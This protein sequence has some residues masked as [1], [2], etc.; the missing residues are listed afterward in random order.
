M[1]GIRRSPSVAGHTLAPAVVVTVAVTNAG[2]P[3]VT[4]A[5]LGESAHVAPAGAPLHDIVTVCANPATDPTTIEYVAGCPAATVAVDV[6]D[7][8]TVKSGPLPVSDTVCGLPV[9]PSATESVAVRVPTPLGLNVTLIRQLDA[10]ASDVPQL[11][12]CA[13]SAPFIPVSEIPEIATAAA[14]VFA[15]VTVCELLDDPIASASKVNVDGVSVTVGPE[16]PPPPA[17]L[18]NSALLRVGG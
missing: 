6:A 16:L 9:A 13:K 11:L 17:G 14:A 2:G 15:T 1:T 7:A 3:G 12:L 10:A 8:I 5:V 4:A 18:Y